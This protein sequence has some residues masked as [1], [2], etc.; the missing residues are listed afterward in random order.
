[1]I[2]FLGISPLS[3]APDKA[4]EEKAMSALKILSTSQIQKIERTISDESANGDTE[5]IMHTRIATFADVSPQI[6]HEVAQMKKQIRYLIRQIA[7]DI[8]LHNNNYSG[9]LS[10]GKDGKIIYKPSPN[11]SR[12]LN[13]Q[14]QRLLKATTNMNVSIRSAYIALKL[15][16]AM[17]NEIIKKA[18]ET[19]D[20]KS[21][22]KLYMK[23]AI[24][25]YEMSD[26]VLELL[27]SLTLDGKNDILNLHDTAKN[28]AQQ[29]IRDTERLKVKA[30]TLQQKGLITP[31][32]L[33]KELDALALQENAIQSSLG[34]WN[35]ILDKIGNY[36][37]YLKKLKAQRDLVEYKKDKAKLQI[38]TLQDIRGVAVLKEQIG[39]IDNL[40]EAVDQLD[41]LVLDEDTVNQLLGNYEN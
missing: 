18:R 16:S 37:K 41:L 30:R 31:D 1:M 33:Q 28:L 12:R 5:A 14:R 20:R 9:T 17:N 24:Y 35:E 29:H 32:K 21:K 8:E 40:V 3:A 27:N 4:Y 23:Q 25:V 39:N 38:E 10:M 26:I 13:E 22:E 34:A 2:L 11:L 7:L 6:R 19:K 15:L 36:E